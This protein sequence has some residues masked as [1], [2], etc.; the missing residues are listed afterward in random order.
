M[1]QNG[2]DD[3]VQWDAMIA[4]SKED[5]KQIYFVETKSTSH[6]NDILGD[7]NNE[8]SLRKCLKRRATV[9][10]N[11]MEQLKNDDLNQ[12]KNKTVLSQRNHLKLF[13]NYEMIVCYSSPVVREW[14]VKGLETLKKD[15]GVK[16]GY[17]EVGDRF[18]L[19][20]IC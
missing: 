9:T 8:D 16:V 15:L 7:E 18:S 11:M 6:I 13:L 4:V 19:K 14:V 3:L 10:K 12:I 5:Q 1:K 2:K 17:I 20:E